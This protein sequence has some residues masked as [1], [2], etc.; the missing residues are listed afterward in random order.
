MNFVKTGGAYPTLLSY[1]SKAIVSNIVVTIF[2]LIELFFN[3][4]KINIKVLLVTDY[5]YIFAA[6]L[7][8]MLTF[9][10]AFIFVQLLADKKDSD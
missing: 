6:F 2:S 10:F 8:I 1:L 7:S 4:P 3:R 5:C 9:R